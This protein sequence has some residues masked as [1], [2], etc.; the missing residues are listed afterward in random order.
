MLSPSAFRVAAKLTALR[1]LT[2]NRLTP[3]SRLYC[4]IVAST[5]AL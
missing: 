1:P 3:V 4:D 2:H 5:P